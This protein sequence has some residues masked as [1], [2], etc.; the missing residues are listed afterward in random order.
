MLRQFQFAEFVFNPVSGLLKRPGEEE[1][2][3]PPQP[4]KLLALLLERAPEIVTREEIRAELWPDVQVDFDR[5]LHFCIRQIRSALG[6]S[7]ADP[8]YIGNVPRRG[9]QW[10]TAVTPVEGNDERSEASSDQKAR[11]QPTVHATIQQP[12]AQ[13]GA[14]RAASLLLGIALLCGLAYWPGQ[15]VASDSLADE[16][17]SGQRTS[18]PQVVADD[19]APAIRLAIMPFEA[20]NANSRLL[21]ANGIA[22]RLVDELTNAESG[23]FAVSGSFEVVGPTTTER[24]A[25]LETP[26]ATLTADYQIDY[27]LNGRI[28][29][30]DE[31]TELLGE[32]IRGTDGAHVWTRRFSVAELRQAGAETFVADAMRD[33]LQQVLQS[34]ST[35]PQ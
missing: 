9:Y 33:G 24:Y 18:A 8:H 23:E 15:F 10:L 28:I 25:N 29:P 7:A 20:G 34:L 31:A 6:E 1:L 16:N 27:V 11:Q 30:K 32:V 21:S 35:K 14:L 5:N 13:S 26:L 19:T 4:A 12:P 17:M 2:R 22:E 3:L